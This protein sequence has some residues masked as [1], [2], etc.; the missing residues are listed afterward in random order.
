MNIKRLTNLIVSNLTDDL[1]K[2]Q[3]KG[4]SNPLTGHCYVASEALF[5]MLGID[6]VNWLP[7]NIQ[8]EK[9]SH[10]YLKNKITGKILDLTAGQFKTTVPYKNGRGRGFLTKQPSKR[11]SELIRR[12]KL[13][14]SI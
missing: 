5:H 13:E 4:N 9:C 6:A 14:N 11:A 1:R 10:W 12:V 3:Y 7:C 2:K 8:H